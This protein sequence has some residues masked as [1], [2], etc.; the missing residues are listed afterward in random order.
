MIL[1]R[2]VQQPGERRKRGIDYHDFLE[3]GEIITNVTAAVSPTTDTPLVVSGVVIDPDGTEFAYFV[4]GGEN[5]VSYSVEF[6]LTTNGSQ[7][8]Q[9]TV[10]FD[11]E[12]DE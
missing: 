3:P 1:G 8:K 10:E 5:G 4:S 11:I 6:T 9:D 7:T 2:Y 12:E